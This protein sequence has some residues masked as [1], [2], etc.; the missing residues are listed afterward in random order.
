MKKYLLYWSIFM[1]IVATIFA[2]W[3][4][5]PTNYIERVTTLIVAVT[6][7]L[8]SESADSTDTS[9]FRVERSDVKKIID[10]CE[11]HGGTFA[12]ADQTSAAHFKNDAA[13]SAHNLFKTNHIG[14]LIKGKQENSAWELFVKDDLLYFQVND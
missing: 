3:W 4:T 1:V 2:W 12:S 5:R 11:F 14:C 9:L 10:G 7:T 13:F 6:D 8:F